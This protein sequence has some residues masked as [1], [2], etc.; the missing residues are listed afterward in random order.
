MAGPIGTV[1]L[2]SARALTRDISVVTF[3]GSIVEINRAAYALILYGYV[4]VIFEDK[5]TNAK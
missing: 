3:C 4:I 1:K 2:I 5:G